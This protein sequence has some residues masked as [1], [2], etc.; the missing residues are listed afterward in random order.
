MG[1]L[2]LC[3]QRFAL[4]KFLSSFI[5]MAKGTSFMK[6]QSSNNCGIHLEVKSGV[7]QK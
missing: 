4:A 6:T 3:L 1:L 2:I 5:G 7:S